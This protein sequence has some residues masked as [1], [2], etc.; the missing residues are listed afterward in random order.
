MKGAAGKEMKVSLFI[1]CIVDQL[2]PQTGR[3][4]VEVLSR[5]GVAVTFNRRQTCCGQPA[6][7][8]GYRREARGAALAALELFE[9]EL[10]SA[11]YVVAP[12]GSCVAMVKNFYPRLF[13]D[14][15]PLAERAERV[16]GRVYEFSQFLTDVLGVEDVGASFEGRVTYHDSCHLL[17]ELGVSGQPRR[18]IGAVRGVEFV[19]SE[20]AA[21]C[22]GFGGAFAV[23]YADISAA[24]AEEKA[25][26]VERSGAAA[27]VACDGGCL[28]QLAGVL[29][30]R[31]SAV[32]CL[33]L[34]ELLA[35]GG[36]GR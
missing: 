17:R 14:S 26:W 31:G 19:E 28:L 2:R 25:D 15:G 4:V 20:G 1:T 23:K 5:L 27:V 10:R 7:N 12:S 16:A 18:L 3:A 34:A 13:A 21:G 9:E 22:C 32:A 8:A 24:I 33:H 35:S 30:R 6:F 11:D 36:G 29:E